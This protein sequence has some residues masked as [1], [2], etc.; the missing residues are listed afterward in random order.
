MMQPEAPLAT[1]ADIYREHSVA[2]TGFATVLVGPDN[3]LDVVSS[4][5]LRALGAPSWGS[6]MNHRAYL[7]QA[8]ANEA[9]NF[10][11]G[12]KRRHEREASVAQTEI[13]Y[14]VEAY[15][16]VLQAV[17]RLSVRQRA[18]VYLTYWEDMTDQMIA[19]YLNI[20]AGSARRHLARAR[21]HL[22]RVLDE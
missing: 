19:D 2:L 14:P 10:N 5:V 4:A 8:V 3:A 1:D 7:Y 20:S 15:P 12:Q 18:V 9:R 11:R 21:Q 6:V 17:R 13:V 16:E 22:R